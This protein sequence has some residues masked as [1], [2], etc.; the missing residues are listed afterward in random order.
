LT[1]RER[2]STVIDMPETRTSACHLDCP[3]ACSLEVVVE[4]GKLVSL[5]GD[6]RNPFTEA[7]VCAKVRGFA[8]HVYGEDRLRHPLARV[9]DKGE[10]RFERISWDAALERVA[11]ELR[12]ARDE[13]GGE[14]ILPLCYGGSNGALTQ[15]SVDARLFHRLGASR[16]ARTVCAAPT[17]KAAEG[18][19][20]KMPGVALPD[21]EHARFIVLWGVNPSASGIHLVPTI[22]RA[23]EQGAK[24]VV[25]DP[26]RTQLARTA[27]LHVAPR[28]GTDVVVA[29]ALVDWLFANGRADERFLAEHAT[30]TDELRRR[31]A[32]WPIARA[33]QV[34]DVPAA[35]LERLA[36]DYADASPAVIR[37]GWGV[38]RNRNGGSSVAAI[39]ALPAV[40]GKFGVRGG[41]YTMSN[42]RMLALDASRA[43]AEPAPSTR[44]INMNLLG[45]TLLATDHP[46]VHA[47]FVYNAN[48]L[49]TLPRQ[50]LVRKGLARE[51][52]FT[53]V[54]DQVMTDTARWA[55]V[56][57]P[58]TTFLEHHEL[59]TSY[60]AMAVQRSRPVIDPVGESRPNYEVFAELC[61]RLELSRPGDPR[62]P[63]ELVA[64]VLA[65]SP[66]GERLAV[67]LA[68]ADI[69]LPRSPSPVQFVDQL[70]RTADGRIHL[71][72]A[73][74]DAAAPA[75]LYA[76]GEGPADPRWPLVL[77]SPATGKTISSTLGQLVRRPA[78]IVIHP[79]DA[80]P[81]GV[82][83]GDRVRVRSEFGDVRCVAAVSDEVRPG[84]VMLPKGLWSRHTDDGATANALCP[85]GLSD[86]GGGAT[87]NDAR[88][89][90]ERVPS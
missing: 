3:D 74:L 83:P 85:D 43:A 14:S 57:L 38:E 17:G 9:G 59:R 4:H 69:A 7:F 1:A 63:D 89:E 2:G 29:L 61:D 77:V 23:R 45:R 15:D 32:K 60:G 66:D 88:V 30:G 84:V 49:A 52:L 21:I 68:D 73:D 12:H 67:A 65:A 80:E 44:E 40:A 50:D 26:R 75:G 82:A 79:A 35:D 22:Q 6:R 55:D 87:F 37:C 24:L 39:L 8:R 76:Y 48:P 16:L 56:V 18:L 86:L 72:P 42:S 58:A 71:C 28:P 11:A 78:A 36:R 10:G 41:G 20:G 90:V 64:A 53:V 47:L 51:D 81:R 19:Y 34:A 13:Y 25:V 54:F 5:D 46:R 31:A 33:A 62:T 27:D 70:P